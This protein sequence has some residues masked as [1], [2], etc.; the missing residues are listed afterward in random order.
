MPTDSSDAAYPDDL[1]VEL[2]SWVSRHRAGDP[3]ASKRLFEC[4]AKRLAAL[5]Q[6][7]LHPKVAARVDGEDIVQSVFRSFFARAQAGQFRFENSEDIWRLLVTIT[8][9]KARY[10]VRREKQAECRTV[11]REIGQAPDGEDWLV[12]AMSEQPSVSDAL[13]LADEVHRLVEGL[14]ETYQQVLELRLADHS[15]AEIA[16]QLRLSRQSVYH[17]LDAF[18]ERL[19]RRQPT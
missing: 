7:H 6:R 13:V 16:A 1:S 4:F 12:D 10:V 15:V 17:M 8:L 3:E 2:T 18:K 14:P 11:D 5:A 9:C 19:A